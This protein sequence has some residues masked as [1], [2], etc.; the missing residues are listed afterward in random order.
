MVHEKEVLDKETGEVK[1]VNANFV[2]L[3]D[4]NIDLIMQMTHENPTALRIFLWIM[5]YMDD[6]NAL[7][8]SQQAIADKLNLHK[9][10]IYLSV[11]YLKEK[12]ALTI[13]KTGNSTVF[14]INSDIVW[15]DTADTKRY[16]HFTAKVFIS[17][18][19][20]NTDVK[21]QLFGHIAQ[22]QPSTRKRQ[23]QLDAV[24][25]L[26]GSATMLAISIFSLAQLIP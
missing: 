11:K 3:Y 9:N 18:S 20:Q 22:K 4:D 15:R 13:L 26:G 7:V 1:K 16:A 23:K 14:A 21:T 19:E 17:E 12:K 6:R 2:Q 25:G 8:V 24:I 10:T 5:K